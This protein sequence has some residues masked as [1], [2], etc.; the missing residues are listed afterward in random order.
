MTVVDVLGVS[1]GP[2]GQIDLDDDLSEPRT[3]VLIAM[4]D[5]RTNC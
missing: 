3:G 4:I 2:K 1:H 5:L